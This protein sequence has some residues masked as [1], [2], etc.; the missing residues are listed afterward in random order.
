MMRDFDAATQT[1]LSEVRNAL[2]NL[3]RE[4]VAKIGAILDRDGLLGEEG[5]IMACGPA[6]HMF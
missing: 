3:P 5:T 6:S 2:E 1:A 4:E